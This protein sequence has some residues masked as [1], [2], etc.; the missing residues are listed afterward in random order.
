MKF[1]AAA[2]V[3]LLATPAFAADKMTLIL[4]WFVNPDPRPDYH[5]RGKKATSLMRALRLRSS[6]LPTPPIRQ[7][8]SPQAKLKWRFPISRSY[9]FRSMKACP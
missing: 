7:N 6:P 5:R 9:T 2:L 8:W 3:A 1:A 4:D